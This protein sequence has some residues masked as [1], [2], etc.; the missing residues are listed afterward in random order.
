MNEIPRKMTD[1]QYDKL[2]RRI[3]E[4]EQKV[5]IQDKVIFDQEELRRVF[6]RQA[7]IEQRLGKIEN[8][9]FSNSR[10]HKPAD[11]ESLS[12]VIPKAVRT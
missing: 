10:A 11:G 7:L 3:W 9:L 5:A 6:D 8:A 12:M 1:D 2:L 4:L